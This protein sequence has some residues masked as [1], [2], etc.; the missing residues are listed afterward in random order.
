MHAAAGPQRNIMIAICEYSRRPNVRIAEY[1]TA[2][3]YAI[4][5][6]NF[7]F[8]RPAVRKSVIRSTP[9]RISVLSRCALLGQR[10]PSN[11]SNSTLPR[12]AVRTSVII[13]RSSDFASPKHRTDLSRYKS[14][15]NIKLFRNVAYVAP[16]IGS[17]P[18]YFRFFKKLFPC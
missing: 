3:V 13:L 7:I 17:E 16:P 10:S 12:P 4:S 9:I 15:Q 6:L 5:P 14:Q 1:S 2:L 8:L 11:T 18:V